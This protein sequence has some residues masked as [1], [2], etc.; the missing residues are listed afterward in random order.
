MRGGT[1]GFAVKAA[2]LLGLE[3]CATP[4]RVTPGSDYREE[5][6]A[7]ASCFSRANVLLHEGLLDDS[8]S[9]L[10]ALVNAEDRLGKPLLERLKTLSEEGARHGEAAVALRPDG[11][12]GHLYLALNLAIYGLTV[13]HASALIKGLPGRI[14]T[15]YGRAIEIDASYAAGGAYRLKGKFLMSAPWPVGDD[16]EAE[17]ALGLANGIAPV[18]QNWLFLG[19]L[20]FRQGRH[21]HAIAMWKRA[22]AAPVHP[23]TETIDAAVLELARRRLAAASSEE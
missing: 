11:V 7:A 5:W 13:S 22:C 6:Q 19:D 15:G 14:E 20:Y 10:L 18:R 4:P 16:A 1:L 2:I 9:D 17:R 21:P 3:A 8:A 12:E 23:E